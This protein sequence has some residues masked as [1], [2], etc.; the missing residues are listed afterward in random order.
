MDLQLLIMMKKNGTWKEKDYNKYYLKNNKF[1]IISIKKNSKCQL[2]LNFPF[3]I[4]D[5][6]KKVIKL[7]EIKYLIHNYSLKN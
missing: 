5:H 6:F 1:N 7:N 2:K 3:S 4:D